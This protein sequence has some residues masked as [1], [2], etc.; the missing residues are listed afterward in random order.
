M[1]K[2]K[3]NINLMPTKVNNPDQIFLKTLGLT[4]LQIF[5]FSILF[6]AYIQMW[7][8]SNCYPT[9][10]E[11]SH[12][13]SLHRAFILTGLSTRKPP[14][15]GALSHTSPYPGSLPWT[16]LTTGHSYHILQSTSTST[17]TQRY[18]QQLTLLYLLTVSTTNLQVLFSTLFYS[19]LTGYSH[20]N[21]NMVQ[22]YFKV[23]YYTYSTMAHCLSIWLSSTG[24]LQLI[25]C[26]VQ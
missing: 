13:D 19:A 11:V 12:K 4:F 18:N 9:K 8:G 2:L 16:S 10:E 22:T 20:R 26:L 6:L 14:Q 24:V 5:L 15:S 7:T 17:S 25:I 3:T 23:T 1:L 21:P